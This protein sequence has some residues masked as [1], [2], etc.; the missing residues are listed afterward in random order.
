MKK[1]NLWDYNGALVKRRRKGSGIGLI[2]F[3]ASDVP[4]DIL[5]TKECIDN[6]QIRM[7][8]KYLK[9]VT[10]EQLPL[11]MNL[12]YKSQEFLDMF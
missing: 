2:R 11:Y 10:R 6:K 7:P 8:K 9:R 12:K 5:I 3:L 1:E 4:I